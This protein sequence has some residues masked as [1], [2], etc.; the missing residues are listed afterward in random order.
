[1]SVSSPHTPLGAMAD[2]VARTRSRCT[3]GRPV[4]GSSASTELNRSSGGCA[5]ARL[6]YQIGLRDL[7]LSLASQEGRQHSLHTVFCRTPADRFGSAALMRERSSD[8]DRLH[9]TLRSVALECRHDRQQ[10]RGFRAGSF[11]TWPA[12]VPSYTG[13]QC[14]AAGRGGSAVADAKTH[15]CIPA[16]PRRPNTS[17]PNRLC[18]CTAT[19]AA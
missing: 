14:E 8:V 18:R 15:T 19:K 17:A 9:A 5:P 13:N 1:M 11:R 7:C 2:S 16:A 6:T 10:T 3:D 12:V 4:V